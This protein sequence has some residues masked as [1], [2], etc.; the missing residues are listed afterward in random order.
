MVSHCFD[1]FFESRV[2]ETI[3]KRIQQNFQFLIWSHLSFNK[4]ICPVEKITIDN[5]FELLAQLGVFVFFARYFEPS[6][7]VS[8]EKKEIKAINFLRL[9][10]LFSLRTM[11]QKY[12]FFLQQHQ[13]ICDHFT[14]SAC[15][16]RPTNMHFV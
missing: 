4:E 14:T 16:L 15:G 11:N 13:N 8:L 6:I 5:Y 12:I 10:V 9:R 3:V 7:K 2:E 1:V